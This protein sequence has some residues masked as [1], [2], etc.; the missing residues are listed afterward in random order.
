MNKRELGRTGIMVSEL[1][2][3]TMTFGQQNTQ[4]EGHAQLDLALER[5]INFIDTAELYAIPPRAETYGATETIIGNWLKAR[6]GRDKLVIASKVVGRS[7]SR[8]IGRVV[9]RRA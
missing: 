6:G 5:G 8:G 2:L 1:C 9:S 7:S 3:G 4:A